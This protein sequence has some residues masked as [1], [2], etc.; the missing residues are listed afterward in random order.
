MICSTAVRLVTEGESVLVYFSTENT[1]EYHEVGEQ[2][3]MVGSDLAPVVEHLITSYPA[4]KKLKTEWRLLE[5]SGREE[6]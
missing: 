6:F 5:T 1:R 3:L 4:W 2:S